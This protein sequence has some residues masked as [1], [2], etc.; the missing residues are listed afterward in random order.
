MRTV[1]MKSLDPV[2]QRKLRRAKKEPVVLTDHGSPA[3]VVRDLLDDDVADELIAESPEFRK[4][5][6]LARR[7]KALGQV[8][9]LT[10]LRRKYK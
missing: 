3:F 9:T 5:V 4:T 7:Q 8:K 6:R 10:E 2:L 1:E